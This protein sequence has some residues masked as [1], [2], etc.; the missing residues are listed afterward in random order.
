MVDGEALVMMTAMI[1]SNS[2]SRQGARTE[3]SDSDLRFR[4]GGGGAELFLEKLVYLRCFRV[5]GIYSPKGR[6]GG[7]IGWPDHPQVRPG[8]DPRLEQVWPPYSPS[9]PL[10]LAP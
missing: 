1:S 2:P 4:D 3:T 6:S 5:E 7:H 9:A 8:V 10:L